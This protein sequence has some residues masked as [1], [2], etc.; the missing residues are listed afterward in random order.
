MSWIVL[1]ISALF[2]AVWA[3]ALGNSEH[4]T[5]PVSTAVF[6]V[7]F[8][9]SM[10]GLAWATR[11]IAIGTAYAAWTG[12]GA[13]LTVGYAMTTGAEAV[14]WGKVTFL[15]GIILGVVG[16]KVLPSASEAPKRG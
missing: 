3:T 12:L 2:E 15:A 5:N 14:S 9:V 11:T 16:L 8:A 1:I 10:V 13:A 4:F 6:L 7:A